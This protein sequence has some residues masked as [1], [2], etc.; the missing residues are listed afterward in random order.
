MSN[1]E[2]QHWD[3]VIASGSRAF[4]LK[5]R[6]LWEYRDL[7]FLFVKRDYVSFYKQT[8]L[9][10]IWYFLQ[11]LFPM[12]MYIFIFGKVAKISTDTLPPALF[13]LAGINAW[14]YFA[15]CLTKT[16]TVFKDNADLFGKVHFP[17]LIVPLSIVF[18]NLLR[19][20]IQLLL[21]MIFMIYYSLQ[22]NVNFFSFRILFL[23]LLIPIIA[24]QGL[25]IGMMISAMTTKYRD[26]ALL[27]NFG[28]Q[29]LMYTTT[30]VYP[31]SVLGGK[32]RRIIALNPM[33][34]VIEG[35]RKILFG[36]GTLDAY[37]VCYAVCLSIV[38]LC[39]GIFLFNK[40]EK[41][42]IDTI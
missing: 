14:T 20:G 5:L 6:N 22:G 18:S 13:Y 31:L 40:I 37:S 15:E 41:S 3:V 7:L 26:F 27:L 30:V 28:V 25:G 11:P 29:L 32:T 35:F 33:T 8:I 12:S 17:R 19:F 10:P 23:P 38:F 21:L 42:F 39:S 36:Q 24:A 1:P 2:S 9:G 16:A 4:D 34:A